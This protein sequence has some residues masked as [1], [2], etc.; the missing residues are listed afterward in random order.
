[1]Q[2]ITVTVIGA[3]ISGCLA[4]L[5]LSSEYSKCKVY[6]IEAG[7]E[8]LPVES[9]S[10]NECYKLHT[11]AHFLGDIKTA[12]HCLNRSVAFARE[13]PH[14]LAGDDLSSPWRRGRHYIMS[15]SLVS[16]EKAKEVVRELQ[17][18]YA[19]LVAQDERNKVF[20]E[21]EHFIQFLTKDSYPYLADNI[22]FYDADN[23]KTD[24]HVALGIETAESQID[25]NKLQAYVQKRIQETPNIIF[26]PSQ[27]VVRLA[28][29][30]QALG[31]L[32]TSKNKAGGEQT[33]KTTAIVNCAWQNI[34]TL[35][36]TLGF[37]KKPEDNRVVRIKASVL[38]QLPESLQS[39]NTCIFSSGPYASITV[40]SD[41]TAVLTSERWTNVGSFM[42]GADTTSGPTH[43]LLTNMT[44]KTRQGQDLAKNIVLDCAS[45]LKGEARDCFLTSSINELR[46][47][48]VK[49]TGPYT[50]QSIYEANSCVHARLDD[51]VTEVAAGFIEDAS[52]KMT[53][54]ASNATR[55]SL[56]LPQHVETL[57][58]MATLIQQV[59]DGL[60]LTYPHLKA[61]GRITDFLLYTK[62][63]N[64]IEENVRSLDFERDTE[65]CVQN[66][67]EKIH[68]K[69]AS[70]IL[71]HCFS[72]WVKFHFLAYRVIDVPSVSMLIEA[73][74]RRGM[75][76]QALEPLQ[77]PSLRFLRG[78]FFSNTSVLLSLKSTKTVDESS[79][80][81]LI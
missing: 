32:V 64:L 79:I 33:L 44:L 69:M 3:G 74:E 17:A 57:D 23:V 60:Y 38:I 72:A 19:Q 53:Y 78:C 40:L 71:K 9:S 47:G 27:E 14:I 75:K 76:G 8:V 20:G 70:M 16:V 43:D 50:Q 80:Q 55:V 21:P 65:Q 11:G 68:Q 77:F 67:V 48:F 2:D 42:A 1:M 46:V 12:K 63:R 30:P 59:K 66:L 13:F 25:I 6:L 37:F 73:D 10:Y 56:L 24:V 35:N 7:P 28:H 81:S 49:I 61:L 15:N 36:Q 5:K 18:D 22:P 4:A 31:Y 41:G 45:Y 62:Y 54:A 51:G 34:E 29:D 58:K 26:M 39:I 52:M